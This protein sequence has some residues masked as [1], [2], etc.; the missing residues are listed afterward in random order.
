M[1]AASGIILV[2]T[3]HLHGLIDGRDWKE[4]ASSS[5]AIGFALVSTLSVMQ[6][7]FTKRYLK[8]SCAICAL[9]ILLISVFSLIE[10]F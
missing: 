3:L 10:A 1:L 8:Y 7:T 6:E 2:L 9:A 4:I 5:V